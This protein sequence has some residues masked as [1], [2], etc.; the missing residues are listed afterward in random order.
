MPGNTISNQVD[1]Y[2]GGQGSLA[3]PNLGYIPGSLRR[4]DSLVDLAMIP[5]AEEGVE[6]DEADHSTG[7]AFVDFP[8]DSSYFLNDDLTDP[9]PQG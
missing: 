5:I 6:T 7:F 9:S 4:D 8:F 3:A 2:V 1:S